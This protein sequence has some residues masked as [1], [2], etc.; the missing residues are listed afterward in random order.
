MS[1]DYGSVKCS[2]SIIITDFCLKI[3]QILNFK[4]ME[5]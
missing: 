4:R 2:V 3:I 5:D 1:R